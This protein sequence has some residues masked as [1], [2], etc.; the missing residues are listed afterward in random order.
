MRKAISAIV[1]SVATTAGF[2]ITAVPAAATANSQ[3]PDG[4]VCLYDGLSWN[5]GLAGNLDLWSDITA[6]QADLR[7]YYW[8]NASGAITDHSVQDDITS[9]KNRTDCW[10]YLFNDIDFGELLA[11]VGPGVYLGNLGTHGMNNNITSIMFVC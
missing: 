10:I 7:K 6:S 5:S 1:V 2:T 11:S 3:C 4:K 8:H 9:L